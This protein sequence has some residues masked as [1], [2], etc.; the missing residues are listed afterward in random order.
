[1]KTNPTVRRAERALDHT[2][3]RSLLAGIESGLHEAGPGHPPLAVAVEGFDADGIEVA[4]RDLD[5]HD[6]VEALAGI[7]A[8]ARWT[9]FGVIC[10]GRARP[11]VGQNGRWLTDA[12]ADARSVRF[13]VLVDRAGPM[14]A[15]L[16]TPDTGF[17]ALADETPLGRIPDACRRV[18]GLGTPPP[19]AAIDDF[20]TTWWVDRILTEGLARPGG[21]TW[22]DAQALHPG[23]VADDGPVDASRRAAAAVTWDQF[24]RLFAR[25]SEVILGIP[26]PVAAWM[27]DGM[28]SREV[29]SSLPPVGSLLA[30]LEPVVSPEVL[31]ELERTLAHWGV[32]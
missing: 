20:W 18:L 13:G 9:A 11:T 22:P 10:E 30:E 5:H 2:V 25:Q 24:R 4:V 8:P 12:G 31:G 28:F 16:R 26:P 27:D 29:L 21:L 17:A 14:V 19:E 23:A 6:V 7:E 3:L 32:L 1:M 15:G